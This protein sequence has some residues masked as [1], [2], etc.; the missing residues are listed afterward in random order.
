MHHHRTSAATLIETEPET[1]PTTAFADGLRRV[2]F[3]DPPD[4]A[5][6]YGLT[7][8]DA[9][10]HCRCAFALELLDSSEL[11]RAAADRLASHLDDI[12]LAAA[13]VRDDARAWHD[14]NDELQ[15]LL[16]RMCEIRVADD[17]A[18]LH[19]S[20]FLRSVRLRTNGVNAEDDGTP[21]LQDY[22]G[23]QPLRSFLGGPL[24]SLLQDLVR[25]G[26]V[27]ASKKSA[28]LEPEHRRLRLAD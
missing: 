3:Q 28:G 17:D 14:F 6:R 8:E 1:D 27:A 9:I 26:L 21:R 20:Q 12:L 7:I 16:T 25:D 11:Q 4:A 23:L 13:C 19:A 10:E 5:F 15:P 22:T 2:F 24:F 18:T